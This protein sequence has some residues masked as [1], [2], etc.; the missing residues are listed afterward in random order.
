[1][2]VS[3][4]ISAS[5]Q[6]ANRPGEERHRNIESMLHSL[7]ARRKLCAETEPMRIS[8]LEVVEAGNNELALAN[9]SGAALLSHYTLNQLSTSVNAPA[10]YLRTLSASTA[11]QALNEGLHKFE[12]KE[13][14]ILIQDTEQGNL[15]RAITSPQYSRY[16]DDD[17]VC[18]L[19]NSLSADGWRVPPARPYPG[20]PDADKWVASAADVLPGESNSLSIREGDIVGPAGLYSSDRDCFVLMVNQNKAINTPN[21]PMYRAIIARNSEVGA[22][23][24]H[25]E[26][27]LYSTVCG[28]HILWSAESIAT[29]RVVHRGSANSAR[30]NG[31]AFMAAAVSTI[32][33]SSAYAEEKAISEAS[34]AVIEERRVQQITGLS[35]Q[36]VRLGKVLAEQNPQDHNGR[37]DT[38]WGYVNGLTRASQASDYMADRSSID[39]AAAKLLKGWA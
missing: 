9:G 25:L 11:A 26:C 1:M 32:E 18:D 5:S 10:S 23:A 36:Q 38:V 16:W 6:W 17:V 15:A 31:R 27:I 14:S 29:I 35:A 34:E 39:T 20:C 28:N 37:A 7:S 13:R 8:D 4:I 19:I 24:Y 2:V 12:D 22:S 3:N 30:I 33:N 21:G